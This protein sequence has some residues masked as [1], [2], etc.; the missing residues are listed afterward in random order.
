MAAYMG[1]LRPALRPVTQ[2]LL[3]TGMCLGEAGGPQ[4]RDLRLGN[5]GAQP[6]V[7]DGKPDEAIRAVF[8]PP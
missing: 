8:I 6:A 4:A 1:E 7:E 3:G 2:L 5:G